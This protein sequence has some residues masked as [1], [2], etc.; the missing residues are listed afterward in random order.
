M[1]KGFMMILRVPPQEARSLQ[2]T[3]PSQKYSS[4]DAKLYEI[5]ADQ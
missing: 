4:G 2:Q 3:L 5:E 1:L